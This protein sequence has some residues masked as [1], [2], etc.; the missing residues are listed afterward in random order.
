MAIIRDIREVHKS[1]ITTADEPSGSAIFLQR[2]NETMN[3]R[4]TP[5]EREI[6]MLC[7]QLGINYDELTPEEVVTLLT[8]LHKS[9]LTPR[10]GRMRGR[11]GKGKK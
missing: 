10:H 5:Q 3:M 7:M 8:V 6:R 4:G 1:D 11:P 2:L 9:N